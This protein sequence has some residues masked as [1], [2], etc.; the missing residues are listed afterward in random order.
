[1]S[2]VPVEERLNE[3]SKLKQRGLKGKK[4]RKKRKMKNKAVFSLWTQQTV[5]L[6]IFLNTH[7]DI[8]LWGHA[9][10]QLWLLSWEFVW[11]R[12][13]II[14]VEK[15]NGQERM[16]SI[17]QPWTAIKPQDKHYCWIFHGWKWVTV[18]LSNWVMVSFWLWA[19]LQSA[20]HPEIQ[21]NSH[22]LYTRRDAV[23]QWITTVCMQRI[24]LSAWMQLLNQKVWGFI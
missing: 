20:R 6:L 9:P 16:G 17:L 19:T 3:K 2:K 8:H 4:K 7:T 18:C 21:A 5:L 13:D 14:T 11:N 15:R 23:Y 24:I 10:S 22:V 12:H 1:M